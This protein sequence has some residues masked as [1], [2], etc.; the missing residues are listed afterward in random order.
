MH[1]DKPKVHRA[2]KKLIKKYYK[3]ILVL[4]L[5]A[6]SLL[7]NFA[8]GGSDEIQLDSNQ[9][10]AVQEAPD[11]SESKEGYVDISGEVNSPG[12]YKIDNH[13]R[14]YQV[15]DKA[16]GVTESADLNMIN[17]AE[18]LEDG[19]KIII[20][21]IG[22]TAADTPSASSPQS[23]GKVNINTADEEALKTLN[24]IGDAIAARIIEYRAQNAFNSIED[25]KNVNGIG[26][27]T[28]NKIKDSIT[29]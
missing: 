3:I 2:C 27:T 28:F 11:Q 18:I 14:L 7:F 19:A 23:N 1:S 22:S 17:Q 21:E 10:E 12:V 24:G 16:G 29:V 26:E 25:I 6:C 8:N 15:I 5:I 13:T 20:P 9:D 4:V